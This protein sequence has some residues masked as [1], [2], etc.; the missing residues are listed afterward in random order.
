MHTIVK[1]N[2]MTQK[3]QPGAG[4]VVALLGFLL[5]ASSYIFFERMF[6]ADEWMPASRE[7][8]F[9]EHQYWRAWTSLWAHGDL[10]HLISNAFLL[11]PFTYF[12]TSYFG[13]W[14]FPIVGLLAGGITNLIVLKTMPPEVHLIG[15]SGVVYWMG[16]AYLTLYML[17]DRR[18]DLRHRFATAV[19]ISV[20]LFAPEAYKPDISYLSH[21]IGYVFGVMCGLGLYLLNRKKY[22]SAEVTEVIID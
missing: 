22:E 21:L 3:P 18:R 4:E 10:G 16:A 12:L 5:F 14:L 19:F 20:I 6:H 13:L 15:I 17:V 8:V 2:W 7:L 9:G 1:E 11:L